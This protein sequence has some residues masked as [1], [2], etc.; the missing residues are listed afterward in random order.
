MLKLF[1]NCSDDNTVK[2]DLYYDNPISKYELRS[3]LNR[4]KR[5]IIINSIQVN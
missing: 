5:A 3:G 1:K 4:K 2:L